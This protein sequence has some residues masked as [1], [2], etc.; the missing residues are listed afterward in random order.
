MAGAHLLGHL[1]HLEDENVIV[2][3]FT[4]V[5]IGSIVG[6]FYSNGYDTRAIARVFVEELCT[7]G[8]SDLFSDPARV[9]RNLLT[10]VPPVFDPLRLFGGGLVDILPAMQELVSKYKLVPNEHLQILATRIEIPRI[11]GIPCPLLAKRVPVLFKGT[12]YDLALALAA[13][14]AIP[15]I[16]RP[17]VCEVDGERELLWDG[18]AY[19]LQPGEFGGPVAIVAKLFDLPGMGLLF[20]DRKGDF[21]ASVGKITSPVLGHLTAEQVEEMRQHGYS[22]S[23]EALEVPLRRGLIPVAC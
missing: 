10:F 17:V 16:M 15:G 1:E 22:R 13:S 18:G 12:D 8:L 20:P 23:R 14:T 4:C 9:V 7:P 11:L 5:S 21:I 2:S 19:H 6:A 3:E